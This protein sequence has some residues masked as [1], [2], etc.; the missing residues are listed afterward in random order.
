MPRFLQSAF[1]LHTIAGKVKFKRKKKKPVNYPSSLSFTLLYQLVQVIITLTAF[2]VL[3]LSLNLSSRGACCANQLHR[4]A[5]TSIC[6]APLASARALTGICR[7]AAASAPTAK[8]AIFHRAVSGVSGSLSAAAH[9]SS[10]LCLLPASG[11]AYHK[12]RG[13]GW[14]TDMTSELRCHTQGT[15]AADDAVTSTLGACRQSGPVS[16][17]LWERG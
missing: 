17:D 13:W 6:W 1:E 7:R 3:P 5:V 16:K 2:S 10:F 11:P 15:P 9:A 14:L 12:I 8:T 4:A